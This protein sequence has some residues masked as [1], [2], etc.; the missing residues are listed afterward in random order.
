MNNRLDLTQPGGLYAYQDTLKFMQDAYAANFDGIA[1]FVGDKIIM[2]GVVDDGTNVSAGWISIAGELM[3]FVAGAKKDFV[4]VEETSTDELFDDGIERAVYFTKVAKMV[5]AGGDFPFTDLKKLPYKSATIYDAFNNVKSLLTKIVNIEP[6]VIITGMKPV[7]EGTWT[8][9]HVEFSAGTAVFNGVPVDF[10]AYTGSYPFYATEKGQLT[11]VLPSSGLYI[12]FDPYTSQYYG[13]VKKRNET[14]TGKIEMYK[15]L[16]NR[17]E[18]DTGLGKWEWLGWKIC[19]DM[20]DRIPL[21][22]D[23]RV[24]NPDGGL[25][26]DANY[27]TVGNVGGEKKHTLTIAEMPS[28]DHDVVPPDSNSDATYGKTA[29]GGDPTEGTGITPYKTNLTGGGQSHE[30]RQPYRVVLFIEKI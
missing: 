12:T 24:S 14:A 22:F 13:D 16:L 23:R 3:P 17:F 29:T 5:N 8:P 26:W 7:S 2:S 18:L 1:K 27:T 30:N 20:Q 9:S 15:V 11:T 19:D 21:G 4:K 6:A 25:V 28:H 10:S